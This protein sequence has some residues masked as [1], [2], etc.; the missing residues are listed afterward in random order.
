M[1]KTAQLPELSDLG[2]TSPADLGDVALRGSSSVDH[3]GN[4]GHHT[5]LETC[6]QDTPDCGSSSWHELGP[7]TSQGPTGNSVDASHLDHPP[8]CGLQFHSPVQW[9]WATTTLHP[10]T[11]PAIWRFH[12]MW[13]RAFN[14][15]SAPGR[16]LGIWTATFATM[17]NSPT[18]CQ[19]PLPSN[20]NPQVRGIL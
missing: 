5:G 8:G 1:L 13:I 11:T 19:L 10:I 18:P 16:S 12:R 2:D 7:S 9:N 14:V 3:G 15:P 6:V 4:L 17:P 20:R